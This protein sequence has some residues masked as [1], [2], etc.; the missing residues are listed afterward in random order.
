MDD[1][2]VFIVDVDEF[3]EPSGPVGSDEKV[4]VV[5]AGDG[6]DGDGVGVEHVGVGDT[7]LARAVGDPHATRLV[8]GARYDKISCRS[9][10]ALTSIVSIPNISGFTQPPAAGSQTAID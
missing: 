4:F 1:A 3:E 2:G 10:A 5:F 6:A 7:V 8:P 9:C